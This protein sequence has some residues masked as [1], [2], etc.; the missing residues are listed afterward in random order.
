MQVIWS[1]YIDAMRQAGFSS[2][3][4]V[5]VASGLLTYGASQGN[6]TAFTPLHGIRGTSSSTHAISLLKSGVPLVRRAGPCSLVCELA[7][8][9]YMP[10]L[11]G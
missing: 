6:P 3:T 4:G 7:R 1:N 11:S 2:G 5:Y 10:S 9:L 8:C